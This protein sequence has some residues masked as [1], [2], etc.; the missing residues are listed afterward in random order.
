MF[1]EMMAALRAN[2][3]KAQFFESLDETVTGDSRKVTQ[4]LTATRWT[5][6]NSVDAGSSTSRQSSIASLILFMRVSSDFA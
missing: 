1:E 5:P 6:M 3:I 4:A 2:Y